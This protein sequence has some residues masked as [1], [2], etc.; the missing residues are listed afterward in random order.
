LAAVAVETVSKR[1]IVNCVSF[2]RVI[3]L[4]VAAAG[5]EVFTG[6]GSCADASAISRNARQTAIVD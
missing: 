1:I 2:G 5:V 3:A 6:I 4:V